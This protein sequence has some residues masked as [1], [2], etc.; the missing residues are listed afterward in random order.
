MIKN[1]NSLFDQIGKP[2]PLQRDNFF[3]TKQFFLTFET[4]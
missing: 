1:K 4:N 2:T 3:S